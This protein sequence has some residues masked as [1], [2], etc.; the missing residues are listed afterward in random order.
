[1]TLQPPQ[2][3]LKIG[4]LSLSSGIPIKTIRYYEELGLLQA[5]DRTESQY[6]LFQPH[7]VNRLM[8]IK[9]LQSLGLSLH[10]IGECL[11]VYD[12]GEL[13]CGDIYQKLT[14][15]VE[16]IDQQIAELLLLREE[17]TQILQRWQAV[18]IKQTDSICPNLPV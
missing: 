14:H 15:Q 3:L 18:P 4:Q 2:T 11:S 6:R 16:R 12:Q 7:T 10:E 13:P 8:F 17:L 1:M 9:R 5:S